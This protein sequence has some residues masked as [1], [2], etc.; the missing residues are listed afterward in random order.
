MRSPKMTVC[1]ARSSSSTPNISGG[2]GRG[3]QRSRPF[4]LRGHFV[5]GHR[6]RREVERQETFAMPELSQML[7]ILAS[8]LMLFAAVAWLRP[9]QLREQSSSGRAV[10]ATVKR[11]G[12]AGVFLLLALGASAL[13]A[14][15][16]VVG[17]FTG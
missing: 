11:S 2:C 12:S 8:V 4:R 6:S 15:V 16:A 5:S 7:A 1:R 10:A 17:L 9:P 14:A 3:R 13:A